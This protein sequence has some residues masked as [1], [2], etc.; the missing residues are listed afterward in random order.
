MP[1][2]MLRRQ[3]ASV[4]M[5]T[6]EQKEVVRLTADSAVAEA[7]DEYQ[8]TAP[9]LP[10]QD[11]RSGAASARKL[12]LVV[13]ED[14]S[15]DV[16][17]VK[18]ALK[19]GGFEAVCDVVQTAEDFRNVVRKNGYEIVLADYSLPLW[20]GL[21]TLQILRQEGLDIPVIVVSGA[22]GDTR[23]VECIKQGA[24]DYVLKDH[25][26]RVPDVVR[27]ALREKKLRD[28]NRQAQEELARSNRDLEQFA[29]VASHDLQEPLRMVAAY[30]Q[31]LEQRYQ[32]KLDETADKYIHYAVDGALRMQTL[33][34]DLLAFSR[35]GREGN[36]AKLVDVNLA[37]QSALINLQSTIRDSNAQVQYGQLPSMVADHSQLTQLFQNLIGNAIKFRG[38][39]APRI[40]ISAEK[41]DR[42]WILSVADNGIGIAPEYAETIF[43]IF[44]RLHTREEYA[45][46]GIGL[47]ICK[48]VVE[49]H[50][51]RIWMES[52]P[53]KGSTFRFALPVRRARGPYDHDTEN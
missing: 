43:V 7:E 9:I 19:K 26:L 32:G 23:A 48:K 38:Q 34:Q 29:Y 44:K 4:A 53:G 33:V 17:L 15:S 5:E 16:E 25:L 22:L 2:L 1:I 14:N 24:A 52:E 6:T 49:Q 45:G 18:H 41:K 40:A 10:A 50:G 28:D 39:E 13:V 51:G 27:R 47:A 21:E 8:A 3:F 11:N 46:S 37:V 42:E 35:V 36:E 20:N 31:L 12:R 30:T